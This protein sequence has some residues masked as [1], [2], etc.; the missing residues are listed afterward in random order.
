VQVP[1]QKKAPSNGG[2]V[3]EEREATKNGGIMTDAARR[4]RRNRQRGQEGEREVSKLLSDSLNMPVKR[5]LGQERDK[6]SDILTKPYRWEVK[7]RKRIGLIYDWLEEAQDGLQNASERP[8]V[9]FRA[10]GKGWLVA[11]PLEEAIRLIRE[12]IVNED[13][14]C[15][16]KPV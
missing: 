7:R 12:E 15:V 3:P 13:N 10:D 2:E 14:G 4:G 6:G 9:A 1:H 5:L 16:N 8:L 11:M